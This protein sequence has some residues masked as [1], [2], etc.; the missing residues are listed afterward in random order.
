MYFPQCIT[1][2]IVIVVY[3]AIMMVCSVIVVPVVNCFLI[4]YVFSVDQVASP[5]LFAPV[6]GLAIVVWLVASFRQSK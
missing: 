1:V 2:M 5:A 6:I 3:F 4:K